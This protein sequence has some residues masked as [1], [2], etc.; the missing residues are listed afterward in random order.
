LADFLKAAYLITGKEEPASYFT[1][2]TI[3]DWICLYADSDW[4]I[5]SWA[6][7]QITKKAAKEQL[8]QFELYKLL[9]AH[10]EF[11]IF[12]YIE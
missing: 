12:K 6:M 4:M 9:A 1:Q 8:L 7:Q 10:S 11:G 3:E 5:S 2:I